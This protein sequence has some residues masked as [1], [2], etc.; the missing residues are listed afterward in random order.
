MSQQRPHLSPLLFAIAL[1][2]CTI[3]T[4]AQTLQ[5]YDADG[6]LRWTHNATDSNA[7]DS[8]L[9][10]ADG[11]VVSLPIHAQS[12][13]LDLERRGEHWWAVAVAK[14]TDTPP[15]LSLAAGRVATAATLPSPGTHGERLI[16][17]AALLADASGLRGV[18]WLEGDNVRQLALRFSHWN[19]VG[20]EKA[21]TLS[22]P[23]RGTQIALDAVVLNDGSWLAVW[24]AFDGQDD[25]IFWSRAIDGRWSTPSRVHANNHLP[26][27]TPALAVTPK[28]ALLAWNTYDGEGYG[29]ELATFAGD[30]WSLP[31]S[32]AGKGST[33][34]HFL[35][36]DR[37]RLTFYQLAPQGWTVVELDDDGAAKRWTHSPGSATSLPI[38]K[39]ADDQGVMLEWP[40]TAQPDPTK[41]KLAPGNTAPELLP[42]QATAPNRSRL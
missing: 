32:L 20:W 25:E 36:T 15:R 37:P 1:S 6:P 39:Q 23:G 9:E 2:L 12:R 19:G 28:G 18:L 5:I 42:W 16:Q 17:D 34:P 10:L 8:K 35:S 21:E 4:E 11:Q 33:S 26:D 29:I 38:L 27:I 24:A 41:G 3:A 30:R 7:T 14:G 22:P 31:R 13:P 40:G